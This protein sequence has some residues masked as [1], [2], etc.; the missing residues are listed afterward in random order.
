MDGARSLALVGWLVAGC[1]AASPP[2]TIVAVVPPPI[3]AAE[4]PAGERDQGVIDAIGPLHV[5][6]PLEEV[7]RAFGPETSVLTSA[8]ES[9]L[10]QEAGYELNGN[11]FVVL[12]F[13]KVHVWDTPPKGIG[14]P[15][16][17][18]YEKDGRVIGFIVTAYGNEGAPTTAKTGVGGS[19][20]LLAD[21]ATITPSLGSDRIVV[22]DPAHGH[23]TYH[24]PSRGLSVIAKQGKVRVFHVYGTLPKEKRDL[25]RA[26]LPRDAS[27]PR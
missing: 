12:G 7:R 21:E 23:T 19:C 2:T 17:K 1:G 11:V 13:D 24:Y 9:A 22:N 8:E 18:V 14:F 26:V 15:F 5:G 27:R 6:E 16:W 10:I 3:A 25:L 4:A 20:F